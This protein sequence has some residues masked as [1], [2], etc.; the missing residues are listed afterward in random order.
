MEVTGSVRGGG[1]GKERISGTVYHYQPGNSHPWLAR[2]E[3]MS[4]HE[5]WGKDLCKGRIG[6]ETLRGEIQ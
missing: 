4:R 5:I 3:V 2:P 6:Y 1:D